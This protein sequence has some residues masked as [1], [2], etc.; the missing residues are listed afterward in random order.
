MKADLHTYLRG[1]RD[2]L[3]WKLDG[4]GEYDVR[5]PLTP[6]ATNLLG[7]VKHAAVWESRYFGIVF[8]RPFAEELP[9]AD[10][11]AEPNADMWVTADETREEIVDLYRRACAHADATIEA[12][13]L[14]DTGVVPWWGDATVTLHAV[15]V[16]VVAETQRHAGHADIVRELIDGTAGLLPQ[17]DNLPDVDDSWWRS[18]RRRV[19]RS[20]L[21]AGAR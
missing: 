21:D 9:Y 13:A 5:R 16:H 3:L 7:L 2:A 15:L 17:L 6:T 4:L 19:E 8:G 11:S 10:A 14:D 20:A 18:H 1:G 12:L